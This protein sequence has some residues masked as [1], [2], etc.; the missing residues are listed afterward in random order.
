MPIVTNGRMQMWATAE[1][2]GIS[3]GIYMRLLMLGALD[4]SSTS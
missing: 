3:L 2:L 4:A 1:T